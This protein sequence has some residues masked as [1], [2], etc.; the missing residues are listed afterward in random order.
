MHALTRPLAIAAIAALLATMLLAVPATAQQTITVEDVA[1]S[2]DIDLP[3]VPDGMFDPFLSGS[4][5][6]PEELLLT[7]V[8]VYD[9]AI[10]VQ[11]TMNLNS[12]LASV[13][14]RA[15]VTADEAQAASA[16]LVGPLTDPLDRLLT[17]AYESVGG[18]QE[19]GEDDSCAAKYSAVTCS[20]AVPL[21]RWAD[22]G[23]DND[24][25]SAT[26]SSNS[27]RGYARAY[28]HQGLGNLI[29]STQSM[30]AVA[31]F[32]VRWNWINPPTGIRSTSRYDLN[33]TISTYLHAGPAGLGGLPLPST[34]VGSARYAW[35]IEAASTQL[36]GGA[37]SVERTV[38]QGSD[39]ETFSGPNRSR[40]TFD[41]DWGIV[42]VSVNT[43]A[44]SGG[45]NYQSFVRSHA[46]TEI[47]HAGLIAETTAD[48]A[49]TTRNDGP[50]TVTHRAPPGYYFT[51]LNNNC[52]FAV[53]RS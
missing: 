1:A 43:I 28:N 31:D 21:Y 13:T 19:L 52:G 47:Q 40:E 14:Y 44:Q 39:E 53:H 26:S 37:S 34:G 18:C 36:G 29:A 11:T 35:Y 25:G 6:G 5:F 48:A 33:S 30:A 45:A 42:D 9:C 7:Q 10:G 3:D 4:P 8:Q 16:S 32:G 17:A 38:G 12:C 15:E 49:V 23:G 2:A 22:T 24:G 20:H 51:I 27:F 46:S 50:V 41:R